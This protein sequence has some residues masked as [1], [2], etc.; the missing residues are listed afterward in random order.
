MCV[1]VYAWAGGWLGGWVDECLFVS[2]C[3]VVC[4]CVCVCVCECGRGR[5]AVRRLIYLAD[6]SPSQGTRGSCSK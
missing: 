1:C 3:V 2:V 4:R 6:V 5:E